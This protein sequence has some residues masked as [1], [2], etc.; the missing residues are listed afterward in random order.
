MALALSAENVK[1]IG[2]SAYLKKRRKNP[3][4]T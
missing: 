2:F 1:R 3:A 4:S